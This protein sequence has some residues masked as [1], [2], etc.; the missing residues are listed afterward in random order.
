MGVELGDRR[1]DEGHPGRV[2][3]V[4]EASRREQ[5]VQKPGDTWKEGQSVRELL[6]RLSSGARV[7]AVGVDFVFRE[8]SRVPV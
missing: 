3:R 2:L 6:G 5:R 4:L 8:D 7:L 1:S